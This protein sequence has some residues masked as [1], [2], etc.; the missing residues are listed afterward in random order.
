[1]G[2]MSIFSKIVNLNMVKS[3]AKTTTFT[4]FD[5]KKAQALYRNEYTGMETSGGFVKT[6]VDHTVSFIGTPFVTDKE[7]KEDQ[8]MSQFNSRKSRLMSMVRDS[9]LESM[10]YVRIEVIPGDAYLDK[11]K[12]VMDIIENDLVIPLLNA[13]GIIVGYKVTTRVT[14]DYTD[15]SKYYILIEEITKTQIK[16]TR[17]GSVPTGLKTSETIANPYGILNIVPIINEPDKH[18]QG[19]SDIGPIFPYLILYHNIIEQADQYLLLHSDPKLKLRVR[20]WNNFK[21][22]NPSIVDETTN[23]MTIPGG[24]V[25][26]INETD[27]VGYIT[28][29]SAMNDFTELLNYIF[30]NLVQVSQTPEFLLGHAI[31]SSKASADSQMIILD[32]KAS[33]KRTLYVEQFELLY[34]VFASIYGKVVNQ[35]PNLDAI[36]MDWN[37]VQ[38]SAKDVQ[39]GAPDATATN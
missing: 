3:S 10:V 37:N 36:L 31:G 13:Y 32:A 12:V 18:G 22:L 2:L 7:G 25:F 27:D 39:S 28:M 21:K 33:R 20:D 11:K 9:V 23:T 19:M 34:K 16:I 26:A 14:Y 8:I 30:Y 38:A 1:M 15:T 17:E 29:T 35:V 6:S 24:A 5:A 4:Q